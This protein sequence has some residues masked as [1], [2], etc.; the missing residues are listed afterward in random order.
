MIINRIPLE[1]WILYVDDES[2][3]Y[4]KTFKYLGLTINDEWDSKYQIKNRI[5]MTR[6]VSTKFT[7]LLCNKKLKIWYR[8]IVLH[9]VHVVL[10][11]SKPWKCD[12]CGE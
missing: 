10:I 2:I 12:Q 4:V 1:D 7:T 3:K 11:N 5:Q 8:M 6:Q 9:M